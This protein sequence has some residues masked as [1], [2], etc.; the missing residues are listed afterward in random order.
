MS[1]TATVSEDLSLCD[2]ITPISYTRLL[3]VYNYIIND[4]EKSLLEFLHQYCP[5]A[6][7]RIINNQLVD[8]IDQ[9]TVYTRQIDNDISISS[10]NIEQV[11]IF[12]YGRIPDERSPLFFLHQMT[13]KDGT[14]LAIG[15]HHRLTDGHGFI[16]LLHRFSLWMIG[17]EQIPP[18]FEHNRS[19]IRKKMAASIT[20]EHYEYYSKESITRIPEVETDVI[21]KR[22]KKQELFDMLNITNKNVSFN[23]VLS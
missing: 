6:F 20:Y 23:D 10:L 14:L 17:G 11:D 9:P 13:L 7:K 1:T 3:L 15:I 22:Y 18:L 4:L 21:I 12:P 8:S 2:L 19:L 5:N 16:S